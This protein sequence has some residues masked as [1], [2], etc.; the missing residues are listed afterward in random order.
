MPASFNPDPTTERLRRL[1]PALEKRARIMAAIRDFFTTRGFL[2]VETPIRIPTPALEEQIDAQPSG[3]A[4]LRTSPELHM[5]RL[6]AAGYDKLFQIGPCFRHGEY[7]DRHNP[8]FCM[9]EWYRAD[10]DYR[11]ILDDVQELIPAAV[12]ATSGDATGFVYRGQQIKLTLPWHV[13]TVARAFKE[14]AGWDPVSSFDSRRF[15][16]DLVNLVEPALPPDRPTVLLDYPVEAAALARC[17][18][19]N[20]PVAERWE[21]Y[22]GGLEIV[23]AFS[24]LTDLSEQRRRFDACAAARRAEG[25]TVYPLDNDFLAALESGMPPS[26]GAALGLDRLVMLCCNA[27]NLDEALPFRVR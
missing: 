21:L 23:N 22:I 20:P 15:E 24:E 8:E 27:A 4:W 1:R 9:L 7:G 2:E 12:K 16:D 13:Q 19:D 14:A 10:A 3:T 17:R 11:V 18:P 6:L 5:K 25:K 26:A